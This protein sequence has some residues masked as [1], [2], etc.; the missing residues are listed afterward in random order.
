MNENKLPP[1]DLN[2]LQRTIVRLKKERYPSMFIHGFRDMS[3]FIIGNTGDIMNRCSLHNPVGRSIWERGARVA[4]GSVSLDGKVNSGE[5]P[6]VFEVLRV[7]NGSKR[8]LA[9]GRVRG[10]AP[11]EFMSLESGAITIGSEVV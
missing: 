10:G 7:A 11:I 4:I 3:E 9:T 2:D 8:I 5:I 1:A 6:A